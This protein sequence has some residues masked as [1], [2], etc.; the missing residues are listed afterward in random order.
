MFT[1]GNTRRKEDR[2]K[3]RTSRKSNEMSGPHLDGPK[4][5]KAKRTAG[6][7]TTETN[8]GNS[9]KSKIVT[10]TSPVK[11]IFGRTKSKMVGREESPDEGRSKGSGVV[12]KSP[13]KTKNQI[14]LPQSINNFDEAVTFLS[15]HS[16]N[17]PYENNEL[18]ILLAPKFGEFLE[19]NQA[20]LPKTVT[21]KTA[22]A[23]KIKKSFS[24]MC[25]LISSTEQNVSAKLRSLATFLS[26]IIVGSYCAFQLAQ[27]QPVKIQTVLWP[28]QELFSKL[29]KNF[30]YG[31]A[32][33]SMEW[34][35]TKSTSGEQAANYKIV[36]FNQQ[37][38]LAMHV[39]KNAAIL[40]DYETI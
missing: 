36:L 13:T 9:E 24:D 32:Q 10:M 4:S 12:R 25:D 1:M 19:K 26:F 29:A 3:R 6:N 15:K 2:T 11:P 35:M 27:A 38:R 7:A 21:Y 23:K 20:C 16:T 30:V 5:Q 40:S 39:Y 28:A 33:R 8:Q 31:Y 34:T 22:S 18:A 17:Y 37:K 14:I